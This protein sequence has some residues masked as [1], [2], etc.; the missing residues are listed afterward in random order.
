VYVV[1]GKSIHLAMMHS[2]MSEASTSKQETK[3]LHE[4]LLQNE[5]HTQA[6]EFNVN[7]LVKSRLTIR[8]QMRKSLGMQPIT[9]CSHF[10][11]SYYEIRSRNADVAESHFRSAESISGK[12]SKH[13]EEN[14]QENDSVF[15]DQHISLAIPKNPKSMLNSS[16]KI[17]TFSSPESSIL[18]IKK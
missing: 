11:E 16:D 6:A 8:K 4:L 17:I 12:T 18:I 14:S 9:K 7:N 2:V 13:L 1:I 3:G 5:R 15:A 10:N